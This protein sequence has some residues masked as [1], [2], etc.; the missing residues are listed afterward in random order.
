M[1]GPVVAAAVVMPTGVSIRGVDDSKKLPPARREQLSTRIREIAVGWAIGLANHRVID[2]DNIRQASFTAMRRALSRLPV[3]PDLVLS[4]GWTIPDLNL[5]C[6]GIVR[7]DQR[8]FSVACASILAKVFRDHLMERFDR[9]FPGYNL[10][11]H[12]GYSTQEHVR[13]LE[14]LGPS[15]IHRRTFAPVRVAGLCA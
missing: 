10:A 5:P 12:K 13:L 4:D 14:T 2:R 15:P 6:R 8:S 7:G 11:R 3:R 1:A 9:L